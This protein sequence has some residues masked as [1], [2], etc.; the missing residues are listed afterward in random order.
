MMRY[1]S[2]GALFSLQTQNSNS[3]LLVISV[4]L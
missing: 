4:L 3:V 1:S 2:R